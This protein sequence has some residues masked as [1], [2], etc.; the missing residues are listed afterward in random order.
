MTK[1]SGSKIFGAPLSPSPSCPTLVAVFSNH[2]NSQ[3]QR[4]KFHIPWPAHDLFNFFICKSAESCLS[5]ST[6][7]LNNA[8]FL[9]LTLLLCWPWA[10]D[11]SWNAS[12]TVSGNQSFPVNHDRMYTRVFQKNTF[13]KKLK[14]EPTTHQPGG[15]FKQ[16]QKDFWFRPS[17]RLPPAT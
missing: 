10:L 14:A 15:L 4:S 11:N 9:S 1:G 2:W 8:C 6:F 5:A 3:S 13:S 7:L 17:L 16:I 12:Y